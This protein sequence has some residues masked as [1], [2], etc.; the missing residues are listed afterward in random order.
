MGNLGEVINIYVPF[1]AFL[2]YLPKAKVDNNC[3]TE[4]ALFFFLTLL[5]LSHDK[6]PFDSITQIF[7]PEENMSN[8]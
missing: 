2:I 5:F 7:R 1:L 6:N 3:E 8:H 4:V